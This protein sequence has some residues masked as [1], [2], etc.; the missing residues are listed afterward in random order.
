MKKNLFRPFLLAGFVLAGI[1]MLSI[2]SQLMGIK[3]E[4]KDLVLD[5]RSLN[6]VID[7]VENAVGMDTLPGSLFERSACDSAVSTPAEEKEER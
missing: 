3:K 5:I 6:C 4:Q 1:L 2:S 7:Y